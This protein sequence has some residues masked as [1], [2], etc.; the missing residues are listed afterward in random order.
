MVIRIKNKTTPIP[1]PI[2]M[3]T[4]EESGSLDLVDFLFEFLEGGGRARIEMES[5]LD[6]WIDAWELFKYE[7]GENVLG[8]KE[9][10]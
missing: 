7:S 6:D 8:D 2:N 9:P 4:F 10:L 5:F 3:G 1:T